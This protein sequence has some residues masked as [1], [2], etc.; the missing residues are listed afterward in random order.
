MDFLSEEDME[1][2]EDSTTEM[3]PNGIVCNINAR[4][5]ENYRPVDKFLAV[6]DG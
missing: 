4:L 1:Y 6:D 5:M 2:L 3:Y